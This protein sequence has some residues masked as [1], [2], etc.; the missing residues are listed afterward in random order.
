MYGKSPWSEPLLIVE[1]YLPRAYLSHS[2]T[3]IIVAVTLYY[4]LAP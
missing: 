1:G 4:A 2:V 3:I